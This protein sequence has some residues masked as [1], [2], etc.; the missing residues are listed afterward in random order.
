M[1]R[2]DQYSDKQIKLCA[3]ERIGQILEKLM[4][5]QRYWLQTV[6]NKEQKNSIE[7]QIKTF[8]WTYLLSRSQKDLAP[9]SMTPFWGL[10]E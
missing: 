10:H 4:R 7:E 6:A 5:A 8:Y 3:S 1:P 9:I 2:T